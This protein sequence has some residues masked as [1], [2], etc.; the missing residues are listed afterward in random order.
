[1]RGRHRWLAAAI[2]LAA[3]VRA[4]LLG[5]SASSAAVARRRAPSPHCCICINCKWIDRCQTYHWVETMH[6]QP[7]VSD[8]PDFDPTDPR[9]Q[10]FI[11]KEGV[12]AA[13]PV[14][15]PR[16]GRGRHH[17]HLHFLPLLSERLDSAGIF[18]PERF[19]IPQSL[20]RNL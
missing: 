14:R 17:A 5:S 18:I 11:R 9:I 3:P 10:V 16:W 6:E 15:E 4:L 20:C 7:H 1:M 8:A 2:W 13:L 12:E 19:L